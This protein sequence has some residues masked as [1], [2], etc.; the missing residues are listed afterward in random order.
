MK[1]MLVVLF[2]LALNAQ[3]PA[4]GTFDSKAVALAYYRSE[5]WTTVLKAKMAERDSAK[6]AG[7]AKKTEELQ[8]M[9][10]SDQQLAHK[11]V[12]EGAP[13]PNVLQAIAP[14]FSAVAK[15]AGVSAI[16]SD[17]LYADPAVRKVDVTMQIVDWL[18]ADVN[19]RE[20]VKDLLKRSA[21]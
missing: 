12:F 20:M 1:A 2:A 7:D 6:A 10:V 18:K 11:Q 21:P 17:V 13:I 8:K 15:A 16:V 3:T 5:L 4:V 19:T 9:G 14:G